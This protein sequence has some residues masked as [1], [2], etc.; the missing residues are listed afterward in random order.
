M[1][2]KILIIDP[3]KREVREGQV[4]RYH[5]DVSKLLGGWLSGAGRFDNGDVLFVDDE[6]ML[7]P[8]EHFFMWDGYPNPLAGLG[9]VVGP[10]V[11]GSGDGSDV[12]TT[13]ED[14]TKRIKWMSHQDFTVW[15]MAETGPAVGFTPVDPDGKLD[16]TVSITDWNQFV[17]E[18]RKE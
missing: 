18:T 16:E 3:S 14:L 4:A 2:Y 12:Q 11:R 13:V 7:K 15:A 8:Q 6:G 9:V 1:A 5:P 10:E 17:E